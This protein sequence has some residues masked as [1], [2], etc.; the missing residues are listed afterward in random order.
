VRFVELPVDEWRPGSTEEKR[1]AGIV[2]GPTVS[3]IRAGREIDAG[4]H[5]M[6]EKRRENYDDWW[7]CE[8]SFEPEL[9]EL[10]GVT[11]SKQGISPTPLLRAILSPELE[12][13]ARTLN[14]RVRARFAVAKRPVPSPAAR[15]ASARDRLLPITRGSGPAPPE[16]FR[17]RIIS[18]P[19]GTDE[20][21]RAAITDDTVVLTLNS[22]HPFH[23]RVY[24]PACILADTSVRFGLEAMLLAAVRA[25]LEVADDQSALVERVRIQWSDALAVFLS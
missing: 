2:G 23:V 24:T 14:G 21:F 25:L 8:V 18:E 13:I 12:P 20:F 10:F 7:R 9:D 11:H 6:G 16:G 22:D 3:V 19:L 17:Y 15:R 4:W 1:A 5:L